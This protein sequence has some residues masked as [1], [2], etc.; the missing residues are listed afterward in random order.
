MAEYQ[1]FRVAGTTTVGN[2]NVDNVDGQNIIY[3]DDIEQLFPGVQSIR[4]GTFLVRLLR[5]SKRARI[6][7]LC[8]K[9][10]PGVVLDVFLSNTVKH[11]LGGLHDQADMTHRNAQEVWELAIQMN[12]LSMLVQSKIEAILTQNYELLEYTIPRL[13][14]V[15]PET[16]T[17]WNSTTMLQTKFRLHF[18]CE[19]GEHTK[20]SG[21]NI[22]HHLHLDNHE[23][24]IVNKPTEFF[25]KYGPFLMVML[26]MIKLGVRIAGHVVP[27]LA[28]LKVVSAL[29]FAESS[30]NSVTS[31]IIKGVDYSL[32]YLEESR[33][34][35]KKS[36]DV[37]VERD[38]R[39]LL[40]DLGSYLTS[41][42]GLEGVE[43]RR[44]GSYLKSNNSDKLLGNLYR[45]ITKDGHVKWICRHHYRAGHQEAHTQKLRDVIKLAKG[46]F[47]E[48]LGRIKV[49]L[50]S[51]FAAA[52][53]YETISKEK[54]GVYDLDITFEWD[55]S[56]SD[57]EAFE[58]ALKMSSVSILRLD[59]P[60]FLESIP[61]KRIST[62]TRYEILV[63]II[64]H[65]NMKIIH[66][67]LSEDFMKLL[68]LQSERSSHLHKLS[69]E[70]T[71]QGIGANDF[72]VLVK[73]LKTNNLLTTLNL[74]GNSIG[75]EGALALSEALETN[76]T[77]AT[78][79]L[80]DNSIGDKGALALSEALK[81]NIALT[82]LNLI[83]NPIEKE[84]ALA[85]S[86]A[87]KINTTLTTL[88]LKFNLIRK[89]GALAL[90]EALK[91]NTTL[92]TLDLGSN[93]IGNEGALALLATLKTNT[94]LT[95]LHLGSFQI[96]NEEALA[97][98]EALKTN[99][100]LTTLYL[101][102]N[103][104]GNEGALA[105]SKALK[106]NT[107][108]TTLHLYLDWIGDEGTL[109]LSKILKDNTTLTVLD[110][111]GRRPLRPT[112]RSL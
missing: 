80:G 71:P 23:G 86:E 95:T 38:T 39:A 91:I 67:V 89:E 59:L 29:D 100:T 22:P 14:I 13:F 43:L 81:T 9:H 17:S 10:C 66:M 92:T 96:G 60:R 61:S 25:E 26:H 103:L 68:S 73:S 11:Q 50:K 72:R 104:I 99:T 44:L 6:E 74:R 101:G 111:R 75:N 40:H 12:D 90:S 88:N 7:P 63:R 32:A 57:L 27:A 56:E 84:G 8:I 4:N 112:L 55:C 31:K 62:S 85:L 48:Q 64:E 52:E 109:S 30:V 98:S 37:D 65:T 33:R 28:N 97:L 47:D 106:T 58:K 36:S 34:L 54:V 41:V 5:D 82:T 110:L 42:E 93:F 87:L 94:T 83:S 69:I 45:M 1:S 35:I 108:L 78:L 79:D 70:M 49:T 18:I 16:S 19:C 21:S 20:A 105:L 107:T 102:G 24:Y 2:I 77:L 46:L 3:W 76:T 51:S 53:F 15:L